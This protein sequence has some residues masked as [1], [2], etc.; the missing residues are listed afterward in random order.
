MNYL[1][2]ILILI[3]IYSILALSLNLLVGYTGL[4][5]IAHAAFYGIGAYVATLAMVTLGLSFFPSM[6]LGVLIAVVLSLLIAFASLRFRGDYFVLASLAFQVIVYTILYNWVGLTRGPYG[7]PGIPRPEIFGLEIASIPAFFV[8]SLV[9]ALLALG[10]LYWLMSSPFGR[11]L[12][13]IREDE[14][15]TVSLGKNVASFK[16]RS[17]LVA[18]GFASIAGAVYAT[19]I[20]YIDPTSFNLDESILLISMVIVGGTGNVKG[21]LVGAVV[22]ILLPELLRFLAIPD[23]VAAQLRLIIYGLLLI[24]MMQYRPQGIAGKYQFE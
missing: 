1:F 13:A 20:T 14:L 19:Y 2:H 16:I 7:I 5:S 4:L 8:F 12:Q 15:A 21:P 17:F 24:L 18:S 6:L 10:I 23:T 11:V 22:L 3:N 9:I